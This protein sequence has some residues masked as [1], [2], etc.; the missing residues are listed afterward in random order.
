MGVIRIETRQS[1]ANISASRYKSEYC[2]NG[3]W[4]T[5][6]FGGGDSKALYNKLVSLG[7]TPNPDDVDVAIG[8][9]SWTSV[10]CDTCGASVPAIAEV[11]EEPGYESATTDICLACARK[12]V[13]ALEAIVE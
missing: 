1:L 13:A 2:Y 3:T 7:T 11:G 4:Q 10:A 6:H 9:G 8:N 12:V 5:I